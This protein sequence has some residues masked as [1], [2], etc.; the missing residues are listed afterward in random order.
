MP[1]EE[2]VA[3][4]TE[5]LKSPSAQSSMNVMLA[6]A[7]IH[8]KDKD[9]QPRPYRAVLDSGSQLNFV[10]HAYAVELG[11]QP[12]STSSNI[13]GVDGMSSKS[14][15]LSKTII[16]SRFGEWKRSVRFHLLPII[17]NSL[18][19][20]PV[21]GPNNIPDCIRSRLADP[22]FYEPGPIDILIGTEIFFDVIGTE[23]WKF[24]DCASIQNTE[25]GWIVIGKLPITFHQLKHHSLSITE[26]SSLSLFTTTSPQLTADEPAESHF[27]AT[28]SRDAY[29]CF[30][31]K[32][33]FAKDPET[34]GDSNKM[35]KKRFFNLEKWFAKE[36]ALAERYKMFMA[37]YL[38][39]DHMEVADVNYSGPSYYLPHH[40]VF[41]NE[42]L[43]TKLRVVFDGSASSNS[44][45][46]LNDILLK[47]PKTQP[48]IINILLRF[49]VHRIALTADVMKMY[50]QIRVSSGDCDFQR[51][52]Y[53][54]ESSDQLMEYRLKT[55]TYGTRAASF[56]ATRCLAQIA[57]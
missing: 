45:L 6:T 7:I 57:H 25:F 50:R 30:V 17:V 23:K 12:S 15:Q 18:P 52:Y 49:R 36:P 39:M 33:P 55:V 1:S 34:L 31:E 44:G 26:S 4:Y 8:V 10:T 37:E 3:L 54:A 41:K 42:S 48:D 22:Q 40:A 5:V 56:L 28:V 13:V 20:Q 16:S 32:L 14:N 19:S 35:D 38:S 24:S 2:S 47:G 46:S 51:I 9:G 27:L 53:R 21:N 43:T 29:G 11:L